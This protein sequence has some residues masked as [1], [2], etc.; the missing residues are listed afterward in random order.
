M[1]AATAGAVA[2]A[3]P[4]HGA[5]GGKAKQRKPGKATLVPG[6]DGAGVG[7]ASVESRLAKRLAG[8]GRASDVRTPG[9]D[10]GLASLAVGGRW[11]LV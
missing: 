3:W 9:P 5:G 11:R 1:L 10:K 8:P 7:R 6:Q 4:A 2:V